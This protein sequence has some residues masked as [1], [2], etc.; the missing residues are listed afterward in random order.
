MGGRRC[1]RGPDGVCKGSSYV[2]ATLS[3]I[4]LYIEHGICLTK[5]MWDQHKRA[6]DLGRGGEARRT[7]SSLFLETDEW[8]ILVCG[9]PAAIGG[10]LSFGVGGLMGGRRGG[11]DASGL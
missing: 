5:K 10:P 2:L 4:L 7:T 1:W 3:H 9:S 11:G 6:C 8:A